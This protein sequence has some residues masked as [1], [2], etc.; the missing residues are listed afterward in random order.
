[1]FL[2]FPISWCQWQQH[3]DSKCQPWGDEESVLPLSYC[4]WRCFSNF[5]ADF[6]G[7][8]Q[9]LNLGGMSGVFYHCATGTGH[10]SH[11]CASFRGWSQTLNLGVMKS[12]TQ[13][14]N[15]GVMT[16]VFY[17]CATFAGHNFWINVFAIYFLWVPMEATSGLKV[18][19]LG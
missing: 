10:T 3:L 12:R 19:N 16:R 7:W 15:L 5:C 14:F 13:T 18:S 17:H 8:T 4:H 9:T 6:V 11:F 1:M 2:L